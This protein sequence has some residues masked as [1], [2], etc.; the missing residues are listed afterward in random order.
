MPKLPNPGVQIHRY[1]KKSQHPHRNYSHKFRSK[2][3]DLEKME[4]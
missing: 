1:S 2:S 3:K 4:L